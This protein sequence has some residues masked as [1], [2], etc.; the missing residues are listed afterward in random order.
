M[1]RATLTPPAT[2]AARGS[3]PASIPQ[4]LED[5]R[6][7]D[8]LA[9][10]PEDMS[11]GPIAGR[12][13]RVNRYAGATRW[14]Y[15]VATHSVLVSRLTSPEMAL[16]GLLHDIPE[17]F[18][19]GDVILPIKRLVPG[20]RELEDRIVS[21]LL[22]SFPDLAAHSAPEVK[23]ADERAYQLECKY[24]RGRWPD[25]WRGG[26]EEPPAPVSAHEHALAQ[27]YLTRELH[28][29]Q[30]RELFLIRY[31]ELTK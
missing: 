3:L 5:G 17:A 28:W 18:G 22:P 26:D 4:G 6:V 14:P 21:Q 15:S 23:T 19:I 7:R 13:S 10:A 2:H 12:L 29:W 20:I 8:L 27:V 30:T 24:L 31:E 11:I 25:P 9:L 16:A 1:T